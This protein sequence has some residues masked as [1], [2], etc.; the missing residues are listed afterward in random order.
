MKSLQSS[1]AEIKFYETACKNRGFNVKIF[2]ER[3]DAIA[4]LAE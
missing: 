1:I 2:T 4:W 3:E